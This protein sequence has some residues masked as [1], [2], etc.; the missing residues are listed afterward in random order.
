MPII[1]YNWSSITMQV[2]QARDD[3]LPANLTQR[4]WMGLEG[5]EKAQHMGPMGPDS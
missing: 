3:R 5:Y 2:A 1:L 4:D